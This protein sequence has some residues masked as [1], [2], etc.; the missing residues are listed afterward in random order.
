MR[1]RFDVKGRRCPGRRASPILVDPCPILRR[2]GT[3]R[4]VARL[5]SIIGAMDRPPPA[6]ATSPLLPSGGTRA[7][8]EASTRATAH[9]AL[10]LVLETSGSTYVRAGAMALFDGDGAQAGWLSGGCL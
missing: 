3:R 1:G 8:L 4:D 9:A 2:V 10:S 7:V 6:V 5:R